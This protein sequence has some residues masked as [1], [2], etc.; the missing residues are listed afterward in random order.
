MVGGESQIDGR[1][2]PP[3]VA[4][5]EPAGWVSVDAVGGVFGRRTTYTRPFPLHCPSSASSLRWL[6]SEN[7]VA[8]RARPG[9]SAD[10]AATAAEESGGVW[11]GWSRRAVEVVS[12]KEWKTREHCRRS[13]GRGWKVRCRRVRNRPAHAEQLNS[14]PDYCGTRIRWGLGGWIGGDWASGGNCGRVSMRKGRRVESRG[15]TRV[16]DIEKE[17]GSNGD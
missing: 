11:L 14:E 3:S 13:G 15:T 1:F 17:R 16:D 4:V 6:I 5:R 2:I 12:S 9:C 8:Q 10:A 7:G